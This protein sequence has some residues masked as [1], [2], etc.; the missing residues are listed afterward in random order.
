MNNEAY[1]GLNELARNIIDS[2]INDFRN[3]ILD[4]INETALINDRKIDT[5]TAKEIFEI[6]EA[7]KQKRIDSFLAKQR[8]RE[9][10]LIII[11]LSGAMYSILGSGMPFLFINTFGDKKL[12]VS[13]PTIISLIGSLIAFSAIFITYRNNLAI[14]KNIKKSELS[15]SELQM[16]WQI[17]RIWSDIEK[18]ASNIESRNS[19]NIVNPS[20]TIS[21]IKDYVAKSNLDHDKLI[22]MISVRNQTVHGMDNKYNSDSDLKDIRDFGLTLLE[23]IS[24]QNE[25]SNSTRNEY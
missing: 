16:N 14:R 21:M 4:E 17:V 15:T 19:K 6:L 1:Q 24:Q 10:F 22:K 23:N 20:A 11:A 18:Y 2:E 3:L 12:L 8:R 13:F 9:R 5:F 7:I 25:K